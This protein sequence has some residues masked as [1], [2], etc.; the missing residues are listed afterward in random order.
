MS[1]N[2]DAVAEAFQRS[3][4]RRLRHE[5]PEGRPHEQIEAILDRPDAAGYIQSLDPQILYRLIEAAGWE[6]A[7]DLVPYATPWQIQ[8]FLDFDTWKKDRFEPRNLERWLAALVT[9]ASDQKFRQVMRDLDPE[10]PALFFKANLEVG[11]VE[12]GEIPIEFADKPVSLSPDGVYAIVYPE[13]ERS[14]ALMRAMIDRMYETD[15]VLAWTLLEAV[16]WELYSTME[17]EAY[18]WRN[19]RLEEFG[20]VSRDEALNIYRYRNPTRL[21]QKW[22]SGS[23]EEKILGTPD[24]GNLPVPVTREETEELFFFRSFA[25]VDDDDTRERLTYEMAAVQNRAL[26]A[27]GVEPGDLIDA[28]NVAR[29]TMGFLSL[30][31]EFL[32]RADLEEGATILKFVPLKEVFQAGHSLV[33]TLSSKVHELRRRPTLTLIESE[34]FSLLSETDAVLFEA[35]MQP[36]A[37][38]GTRDG[39][40]VYFDRQEQVDEAAARLGMVAFKQLWLFAVRGVAPA[41]LAGLVYSDR[42]INTPPSVTLDSL[43]RTS[44]ALGLTSGSSELRGLHASELDELLDVL[45]SKPWG[46]DPIGHFEPLIGAMFEALPASTVG[47]AS[48]WLKSSLEILDDELGGVSEIDQPEIFEDVLLIA[49]E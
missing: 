32:S 5:L 43:F 4:E 18:R 29:R 15:R 20:Y 10:V 35:L 49:G 40:K 16:R 1:D 38:F 26:I 39:L 31:L 42:V 41:E 34:R 25:E 46:D 14:A 47:F 30:G 23:Y 6:E 28:Q 19:S 37:R 2:E 13:D 12:E 45:K 24:L 22:E 33:W 8:V 36:R 48:A 44:I 17:E 9:E 3:L 21:R 27:D 7:H 11:V